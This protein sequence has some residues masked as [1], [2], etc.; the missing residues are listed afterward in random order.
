MDFE[1]D[2]DEVQKF[3]AKEAPVII[4]MRGLPYDSTPQQIVRPLP[5]LSGRGG[6]GG[7]GDE[8]GRAEEAG[9]DSCF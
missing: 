5:V 7:E 1:G 6:R 8:E 9:R 4:R 3:L 2:N